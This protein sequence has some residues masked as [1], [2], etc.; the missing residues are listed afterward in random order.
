MLPLFTDTIG[1]AK[2]HVNDKRGLVFGL[3]YSCNDR[4][5]L[6]H[7]NIGAYDF[8]E[9]KLYRI[10]TIDADSTGIG[11][12][13]DRFGMHPDGRHVYVTPRERGSPAFLCYDLDEERIVF[14]QWDVAAG[15]SPRV[16]PDGGEVWLP[17]ATWDPYPF[18]TGLIT[19]LDATSGSVLDVISLDAYR[20][21]GV[22]SL[23]PREI[24]FHPSGKKAYVLCGGNGPGALLVIDVRTRSVVKS[25]WHEDRRWPFDIDLGPAP[26]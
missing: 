15:G 10:W 12:F 6:I 4:G 19:V 22:I 8:V 24:R 9:R 2:L 14:E 1:L 5:G 3:A 23:T 18:V 13:I 7:S 26:G 21:P 17:G 25:F 11:Y 20:S 16:T